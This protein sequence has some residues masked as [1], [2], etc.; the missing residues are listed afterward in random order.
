MRSSTQ[1]A[2]PRSGGPAEALAVEGVGENTVMHRFQHVVEVDGAQ[3]G[4]HGDQGRFDA[5]DV[6]GPSRK[7][8]QVG[9]DQRTKVAERE[10]KEEPDSPHEALD[11]AERDARDARKHP[12]GIVHDHSFGRWTF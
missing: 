6:A 3:H 11:V 12:E 7:V 5:D 9:I 10:K 8:V 1:Q 2:H 4:D